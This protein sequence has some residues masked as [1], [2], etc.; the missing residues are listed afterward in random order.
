M[1]TAD[2]V[3]KYLF[4]EPPPS[5]DETGMNTAIEWA[6]RSKCIK[7]KVGSAFIS[8]EHLLLA[9]GYNGPPRRVIHCTDCGCAKDGASPESCRGAHAE[10][11]AI[12]NCLGSPITFLKNS[13]LYIT[14]C[15][16]NQCMKQIANVGVLRIVFLQDY[17]R[18]LGAELKQS[19]IE[20]MHPED[21]S[22]KG[23]GEELERMKTLRQAI[24]SGIQVDQYDPETKTCKRIV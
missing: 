12:A 19:T 17:V 16:C 1:P 20:R 10:M 5:W 21:E 23:L 11:N 9:V 15:P 7:H 6:R 3:I 24:A 2:E 13:T 8:P 18:Y 14:V 4:E 22:I